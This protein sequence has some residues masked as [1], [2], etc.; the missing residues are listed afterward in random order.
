MTLEAL[1][2][3]YWFEAELETAAL[4][5]PLQGLCWA[6]DP[7]PSRSR[8]TSM[9][10]VSPHTAGTARPGLGVSGSGQHSELPWQGHLERRVL[11]TLLWFLL[12]LSSQTTKVIRKVKK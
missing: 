12:L 2:Q 6:P 4:F 11:D 1:A 9:W 8:P 3:G 10:L 5:V 7:I